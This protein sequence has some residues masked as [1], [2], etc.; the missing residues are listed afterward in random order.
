MYDYRI[1][2]QN[3]ACWRS[4]DVCITSSKLHDPF[5]LFFKLRTE[6]VACLFEITLQCPLKSFFYICSR[7]S[8]WKFYIIYFRCF[9]G[10][11]LHV[12]ID[13]NLDPTRISDGFVEDEQLLKY[14]VP[15]AFS[16]CYQDTATAKSQ[17]PVRAGQTSLIYMGVV[18]NNGLVVQSII[19]ILY[20]PFWA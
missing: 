16:S 6:A 20:L 7:I 2:Y 8:T 19:C 15:H 1:P 18:N 4:I 3:K 14:V 11:Y 5:Y 9:F 12:Q 13:I 10:M 17:K